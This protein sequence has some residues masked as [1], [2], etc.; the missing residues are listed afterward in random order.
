MRN[1]IPKYF[2]AMKEGEL[3]IVVDA[4]RTAKRFMKNG[5]DLSTSIRLAVKFSPSKVDAEKV[6]N[7]FKFFRV[8]EI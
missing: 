6:E 3:D 4:A 2:S 5:H 7:M 8:N 1:E